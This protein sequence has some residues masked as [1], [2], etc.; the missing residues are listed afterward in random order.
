[1]WFF[2]DEELEGIECSKFDGIESAQS[3]RSATVVELEVNEE[4]KKV[5]CSDSDVGS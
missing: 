2:I 4:A 5:D 3:V 1:M